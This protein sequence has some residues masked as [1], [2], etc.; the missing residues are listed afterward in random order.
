VVVG[1]G[2][3]DPDANGDFCKVVRLL[4][5]GRDFSWVVPCFSGVA[6]PGL[7]EA[8]QL[9]A[10]ARPDRLLVAPYFLFGGRLIASIREKTVGFQARHPWIRVE[11]AEHLGSDPRILSL[12]DERLAESLEGTQPLPCDTCQYRTPIS[13]VVQN[14][15]GLRALLWSLRHGF[16]HTQAMPHV[17]AHKPLAK[18][19]LV[20]GNADCA[21]GGS[22]ALIDSLR[23]L[24]KH[25]GRQQDI[26]ITRTSCMGR[27]GEGPTVAVYPDGVWYRAVH[28][29]DAGEL[30]RDHLLGDRLVARLV[31]NI[32]Q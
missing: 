20:C 1:R 11:L 30:V 27:C 28:E 21:E 7:E 12:L 14:V 4:G 23:R 24:V 16:T 31:D 10:R 18:H 22:I 2:A 26:R 5:E 25:A 3:S 13:G 15:G 6:K 17:H 32:M 19:V 9:L 29:A 8:L